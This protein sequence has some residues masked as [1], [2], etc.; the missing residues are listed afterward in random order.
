MR[1]L[2]IAGLLTLSV[3][4]SDPADDGP[5]ITS[6]G[7]SGGGAV[8]GASAGTTAD[9]GSSV[10]GASAGTAAGGSSGEASGGAAGDE[11]IT[12]DEPRRLRG[13]WTTLQHSLDTEGVMGDFRSTAVFQERR[14]FW[15]GCTRTP[16]DGCYY[17]DCP[18]EWVAASEIIDPEA[19]EPKMPAGMSV[20]SAGT[21]KELVE[22]TFEGLPYFGLNESQPFW[23]PEGG[24]LTFAASGGEVSDFEATLA[25]PPRVLLVAPVLQMSPEVTLSRGEDLELEWEAAETG[26]VFFSI[27][28]FERGRVGVVCILDA[29]VGSFTLSQGV[30]AGLEPGTNYSAVFRAENRTT[31]TADPW[32]IEIAVQTYATNS[33]IGKFTLE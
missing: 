16:A 30:L 18:P 10:G 32:T 6:R 25:A 5:D 23:S 15:D 1:T 26:D 24:T 22:L 11:P 12:I 8:G 9:G 13:E 4:C 28:N 3:S 20:S 33:S 14:G 7:G 27:W 2:C 17:W 31:V 29:S 19:G 21:T